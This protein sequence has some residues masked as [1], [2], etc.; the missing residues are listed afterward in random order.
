MKKIIWPTFPVISSMGSLME[1]F[2]GCT[3]PFDNLCASHK[4]IPS[5]PKRLMEVQCFGKKTV[6]LPVKKKFWPNYSR[7]I[8]CDKLLGTF[9]EGQNVNLTITVEVIRSL[10]QHLTGCWKHK[11]LNKKQPFQWK[12]PCGPFFFV[13]SNM[14]KFREKFLGTKNSIDICCASYEFIFIG[15]KRLM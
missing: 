5:E 8:E 11:F 7:I 10:L 13:V 15:P 2:W 9:F 3:V 6:N 12:K 1:L 4:T 14:T